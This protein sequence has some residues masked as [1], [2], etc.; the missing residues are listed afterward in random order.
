MRGYAMKC[1]VPI[2][3]EYA[4]HLKR[5]G[6][7]G[8]GYQVVSVT[9]KDGKHFDQVLTSEGCV[10]QVRGHRDVPFAPDDVASVKVNHKRWNFRQQ[11]IDPKALQVNL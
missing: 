6:E 9:L 1:L 10:I 3:R 11:H 5:Q 8:M 2:P 4:D 7:T